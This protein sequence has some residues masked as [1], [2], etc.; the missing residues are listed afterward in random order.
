MTGF[1]N[2]KYANPNEDYPDI[3]LFFNGFWANCS[4]TGIKNEGTGGKRRISIT[5][6]VLHAKSRG[7][8]RLRD[9]NPLSYP[10]I[11]YQYFSHPDDMKILLEGIKF[12]I[13]LAETRALKR[14]ILFYYTK[15]Y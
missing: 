8:I 11:S 10:M 3:Q 12:S 15:Y 6:T 5:P 9:N 14:S 2:T 1:I 4:K 7:F 13:K